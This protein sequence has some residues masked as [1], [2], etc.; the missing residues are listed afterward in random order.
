MALAIVFIF[1][2]CLCLINILHWCSILQIR[3]RFK[4]K[5]SGLNLIRLKAETDSLLLML[6]G[7]QYLYWFHWKSPFIWMLK[8]IWM[9]NN[10]IWC[11]V[12]CN[13]VFCNRI[14]FK[15]THTQAFTTNV[16]IWSDL[17]LRI[18]QDRRVMYGWIPY[19]VMELVPLLAQI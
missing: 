5:E 9:E 6:P 10:S 4:V 19:D 14:F 7:R 2:I 11:R 8:L 13:K 17:W 1:S 16:M 15:Y 3:S 18:K 12:F